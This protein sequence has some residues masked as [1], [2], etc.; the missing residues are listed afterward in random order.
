MAEKHYYEQIKFTESYLIPLFEKH[1]PKFDSCKVLEVG[2]AEGGFVKVLHERGMSIKGLELEQSRVDIAKEKA[3]ELD[4]IQADITDPKIGEKIPHQYDLIVMRDV[5]EHIPN[6]DAAFKN[7]N[8]L[9]ADNGFLFIT[10]PPRFSGFAGHQQNG[11][12][13]FR[14]IP[15]LHL[16]PVFII[17]FLGKSF[18]ESE[19]LIEHVID[20]Y[21]IGLSLHKFENYVNKYSF[22]FA[23]KDLFLFRPIYKIRFGVSPVKVP[24]IP[25]LREFIAFGCESLLKKKV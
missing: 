19:K 3:P 18:D 13:I 25:R 24:S 21:K 17:R 4:I 20:N 23:F 12:S 16:L 9:L 6:R 11:K 2:C 1:I 10:F 7:L 22:E 8:S 14:Y 5:I 15:F